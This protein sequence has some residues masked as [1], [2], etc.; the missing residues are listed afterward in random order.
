MKHS[1]LQLDK[2][3]HYNLSQIPNPKESNNATR[4]PLDVFRSWKTKSS[5]F[6]EGLIEQCSNIKSQYTVML[7]ICNYMYIVTTEKI[8]PV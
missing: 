3:F 1:P 8:L 5:N 6:T 2:K 7:I 4:L